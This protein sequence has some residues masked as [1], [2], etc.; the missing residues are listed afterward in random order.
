MSMPDGVTV[1]EQWAVHSDDG[2]IYRV[3]GDRQADAERNANL[4]RTG[5][6]GDEPEPGARAARRYVMETPDG[7]VSTWWR[8]TL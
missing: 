3:I 5:S 2:E 8:W 7:V 6:A 4:L 1:E